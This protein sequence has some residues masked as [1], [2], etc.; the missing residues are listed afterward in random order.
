MAED[1]DA[2]WK[3][4]LETNSINDREL[5]I[6]DEDDC[7]PDVGKTVAYR[8][9]STNIELHLESLPAADGVWSPLGA[10]AWYASALLASMLL[11]GEI[12]IP[13]NQKRDSVLLELGSGAVGL[14]GLACAVVMGRKKGV[15]SR[16]KIILTDNI[17][18]V[19]ETLQSN[20]SRNQGALLLSSDFE[21]KVEVEVQHFDWNDG[22][23]MIGAA[24]FVFGSELVY[25]HETA[26]A[27]CKVMEEFLNTYPNIRI[28]VIQITDRYGW[29][30]IVV[31]QLESLKGV[32]VATV[33]IPSDVHD[34]ASTMI[35]RGR[36]LDREAY[37]AFFISKGHGA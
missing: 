36:T 1:E 14:A 37:G 3:I 29:L 4:E 30:D 8:L 24:D 22:C 18:S 11:T 27:C 35:A 20:V 34:L 21:Q 23:N 10:D 5:L 33:P 28:W 9:P 31:P 25:T 26:M 7:V 2:F 6:N 12:D 17:P 13:Q 15:A 32:S 16:C 19:L